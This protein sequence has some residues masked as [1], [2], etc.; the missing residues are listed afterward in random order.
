M[1]WGISPKKTEL[2]PLGDYN[3]DHYITLIYHAMASLGWHVGYFDHDGIIAYTPI[4]WASYSEE[5][6]VRLQALFT[7]YGKNKKNLDRLFDEISF[8]EGHVGDKL[9][10]TTQELINY[11]PEKQFLNLEDPPMAGKELLKGFFAPFIFNSK[12]IITPVLVIL[13]SLIY[14]LTVVASPVLQY[15]FASGRLHLRAGET[16]DFKT[17]M[18]LGF[19]NRN[20]VLNGQ[21]WQLLTG[22]FLHFSLAHVFFNMV[23]LAYIGSLLEFKLGKWNFLVMYLATGIFSSVASIAFHY[24]AVTAGASGAIFGLFGILLALLSTDFYERSA[25]TALLISTGIVVAYNII[26]VGE[27]IDHAAHFGGLISGYIF[28]WIAYLGIK[29][30][31]SFIKQWGIAISGAAAVLIFV[32]GCEMFM[33]RY[34]VKEFEDLAYQSQQL[35]NELNHDFYDQDEYGNPSPVLSRTDR[36]D[37][38]EQR[39][40]PKLNDL[41]KLATQLTALKLPSEKEKKAKHQAR[42][43]SL[44]CQMYGYI[45]L[46][47]KDQNLYK[48]RPNIDSLT[49][50][51]NKVRMEK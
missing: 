22:M 47:F 11:I 29:N 8:I 28:G 40:L 41:K 46:E 31:N 16:A 4:S 21:F 3:S 7:D 6:S 36:L 37:T 19:D 50:V 49:A 27:E 23:V 30:T 15:L 12:Y 34:Q 5:V 2:V 45:Y 44:L 32:V 43:I 17:Y 51:I 20:Y 9:E 48:Y 18:L 14:I 10:E 39:G 1:A 24:T 38:I 25:R 13:N 42:L 33:P 35:N 26:P